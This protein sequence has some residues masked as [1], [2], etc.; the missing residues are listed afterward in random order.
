MILRGGTSEG[1]YI[2]K[3]GMP[4]T[5]VL[6]GGLYQIRSPGAGNMWPDFTRTI[7]IW[8]QGDWY[9]FWRWLKFMQSWECSLAARLFMWLWNHCLIAQSEWIGIINNGSQLFGKEP[10]VS[11]RIKVLDLCPNGHL[12]NVHCSGN[13]EQSHRNMSHSYKCL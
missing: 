7:K 3:A 10:S 9:Q 11:S 1:T 5:A 13:W 8:I 12:R 6:Q 4:W 2:R